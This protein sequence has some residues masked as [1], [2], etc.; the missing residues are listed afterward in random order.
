M[1]VVEKK[2]IVKNVQPRKPNK[3]LLST[4]P[5]IPNNGT[6]MPSKT[7]FITPMPNEYT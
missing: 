5:R 3:T 4:A 7:I 6:P 2:E 1:F